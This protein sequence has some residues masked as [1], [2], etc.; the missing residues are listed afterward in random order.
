MYSLCRSE[1][2]TSIRRGDM[3]NHVGTFAMLLPL[4]L[5]GAGNALAAEAATEA[6]PLECSEA[7]LRGTYL[8]ATS[9]F[10]IGGKVKGPFAAAGDNILDGRGHLRT[11]VSY[12]LN[13]K[14]TR[15]E[16]VGGQFTIKTDC[17]GTITGTDGTHYDIF[18]APDGSTMALV[19][20]DPGTVSAE[21]QPRVTAR[22]V[23]D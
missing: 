7:T 22:R 3:K 16:R 17:T 4:A 11:I 15:F 1:E 9:G 8:F 20:T 21:F 6:A 23:G 10:N 13:G 2:P 5:A 18:V 14:I 12:S 19:E